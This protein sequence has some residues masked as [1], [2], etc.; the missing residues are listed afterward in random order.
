VS[1]GNVGINVGVPAP[2]GN[3]PSS[4]WKESFFGIQHAQA[5]DAIEFYTDKKVIAERWPNK[6]SAKRL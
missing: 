4:G 6:W 2:M 1:T 3:F 5:G